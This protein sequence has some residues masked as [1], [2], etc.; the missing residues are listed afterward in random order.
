[1]ADQNYWFPSQAGSYDT[2]AGAIRFKIHYDDGGAASNTD[3]G[4]DILDIGKL[5]FPIGDNPSGA[6]VQLPEWSIQIFNTGDVFESEAI[7]DDDYDTATFITLYLDGSQIWKGIIDFQAIE[8]SDYYYDSGLKYREVKIRAYDCIMYYWLND[9]AV[10][11]VSGYA[12]GME[13]EDLLAAIA[14]ALGFGSSNFGIDPNIEITSESG[15]AY[16]LDLDFRIGNV[17]STLQVSTLLAHIMAGF[18]CYIYNITDDMF[19]TARND[20]NGTT[21]LTIANV[22]QMSLIENVNRI[23]LVSLSGAKDWSRYTDAGEVT[24]ALTSGDDTSPDQV[25]INGLDALGYIYIITGG[26]N[27]FNPPTGVYAAA[28]SNSETY[29]NVA[30]QLPDNADADKR[31]QS[32]MIMCLNYDFSSPPGTYEKRTPV[33][34]FDDDGSGV[35]YADVDQ[36]ILP[37][38]YWEIN[39]VPV[40]ISDYS[41]RE[42]RIFKIYQILQYGAD[43]LAAFFNYKTGVDLVIYGVSSY[44]NLHNRFELDGSYYR[45]TSARYDFAANTTHLKLIPVS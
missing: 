43:I 4:A 10:D 11:A 3:T 21:A 45:V 38:D 35:Y 39:R 9:I 41:T 33:E 2:P 25:A 20:Y 37:G 42:N 23:K 26:D 18:G 32:G 29:I 44:L 14:D 30:V 1:M 8:K 24:Y 28:G 19:I 27:D 22:I 5:L 31:T 36:M 13:L 15:I 17:P 7:L 40:L 34:A 6:E 12:D 16:G